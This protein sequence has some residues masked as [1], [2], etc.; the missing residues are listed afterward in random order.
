MNSELREKI[1]R[2]LCDA[3][4]A[5]LEA[6]FLPIDP[7]ILADAALSAIT[8]AGFVIVPREPTEA[9]LRA[10]RNAPMPAVH[11]NSL[12]A[13]EDLESNVRWKAM[14]EAAGQ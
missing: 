9:M 2:A 12:S 1:A 13:Y 14:I 7:P 11:L 10:A 3:A 6:E 8:E 5:R 4:P